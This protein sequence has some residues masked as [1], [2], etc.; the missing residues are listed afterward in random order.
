MMTTIT[1]VTV[2]VIITMTACFNSAIAAIIINFYHLCYFIIKASTS[3]L[4]ISQT[5]ILGRT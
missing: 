2:T 5:F 1:T 3:I 4:T